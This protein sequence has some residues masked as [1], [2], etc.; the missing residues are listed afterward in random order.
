MPTR[1]ASRRRS[2]PVAGAGQAAVGRELER[3]ERAHVAAL[4]GD[5]ALE[6]RQRAAVVERGLDLGGEATSPAAS[7]SS[8]AST[9]T[10]SRS[11]PRRL[12]AQHASAS[13][14]SSAWPDRA[15]ERLVHPESTARTASPACRPMATMPRPGRARRRASS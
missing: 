11:A 2:V 9:T 8:S 6:A 3:V 5:P 13:R 12:A 15:A 1:S 7:S 4:G 14:T 10:T